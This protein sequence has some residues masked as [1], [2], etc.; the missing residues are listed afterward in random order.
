LRHIKNAARG[1]D[2][3]ESGA[4]ADSLSQQAVRLV[5][6]VSVFRGA[7]ASGERHVQPA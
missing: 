1:P 5:Q 6:L 7:E 2:I 3:E 4:A